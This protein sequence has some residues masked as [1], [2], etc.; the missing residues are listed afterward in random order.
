M[1]LWTILL[2]G[3][4]L[5]GIT[6][7]STQGALLA[8]VIVKDD[9]K[10]YLVKTSIFLISKMLAYTILGY[11]LGLFGKSL[12]ISE[13]L[14]ITL[15]II[16][17]I[18][19]MLS[20]LSMVWN[21]PFFRFLTINPPAFLSKLKIT[22]FL[23]GVTTIF[24]P[25]GT[26]LAVEALAIASGSPVMGALMMLVFTLGTFPMFLVIGL[27]SGSI[28]HILGGVLVKLAAI[29]ILYMGFLTF[30]GGLSLAGAGI[31][32]DFDR[33][34]SG[35]NLNLINGMQQAVVNVYSTS[36]NPNYLQV[37]KDIP[38]N[39]SLITH[40]DLGCT[41][42]FRFPEFGLKRSLPLTGTTEIAFTPTQLGKFQYTC[43]M[44]MYSGVIEVIN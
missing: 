36:Y 37:K 38:V 23:L 24:I 31:Q 32:F 43:G 8:S 3:L 12:V 19:V 28:R 33:S 10:D 30:N 2:T 7:G 42:E 9:K 20:A 27:L 13:N 25:C 4:T 35:Y 6:C 40:G 18:Y 11:L 26:T 15:Q 14:R 21:H 34:S 5:G 16:A 17:G 41:S 22:P 44:G 1:N 39:L 29:L